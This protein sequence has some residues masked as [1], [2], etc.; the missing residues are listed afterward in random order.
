MPRPR[1]CALVGV[2]RRRL[3]A[4]KLLHLRFLWEQEVRLQDRLRH[5]GCAPVLRFPGGPGEDW[6]WFLGIRLGQVSGKCGS[7]AELQRAQSQLLHRSHFGGLQFHCCILL[8][9]PPYFLTYIPLPAFPHSPLFPPQLFP[10]LSS[11]PFWSLGGDAI[12]FQ[13]LLAFWHLFGVNIE[14]AFHWL[15]AFCLLYKVT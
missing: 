12:L 2:G 13:A 9:H 8:P 11:W 4:S 14:K 7:S 6:L 5:S 15:S 3:P 10:Q 1:P